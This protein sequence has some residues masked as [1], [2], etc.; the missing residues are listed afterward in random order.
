MT[1]LLDAKPFIICELG[2]NWRTRGDIMNSVNL[3][4]AMGADALK[5]QAFTSEAL[6][7][8]PATWQPL[9]HCLPLD[10]LPAIKEKCDKAGLE[11]MCS[12]F[13]PELVD[14]VD[15]F[16][17]VHKVASSD[18]SY[19]HLLDAIKKTGKPVILST[20]ASSFA[21]VCQALN[22]LDR[23][24]TVLLYCNSAYPSTHH[25][26]FQ[27][28]SMRE[29]FKLPVGLSDHSL[30]VVYAP[31]AAVRTHG[32][33][34]I[35]K[36]F[37]PIPEVDTPDRPHSLDATDFKIMCDH[38]RGKADTSL[39]NPTREEKAMM[40]RHNRRLV[41]V[42]TIL[43]GEQ[44]VFGKNY[45]AFRALE[46]DPHGLSPFLWNDEAVGPE[47]RRAVKTIAQGKGIGPGDYQ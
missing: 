4:K 39:F 1:R 36:H 24:K 42:K 9:P 30:D 5:L 31:L 38:L 37:T 44:L 43:P 21:D 12:A 23:T 11:F 10:W 8:G 13:S 18:L 34:V 20:G 33:V 35:E 25:N 41:A 22:H 27:I 46:D 2:S 14:A 6:Y 19:P 17:E 15:P 16:V 45:G 32:A 7:G 40:L 26:L 29:R 3:V 47:L 28:D